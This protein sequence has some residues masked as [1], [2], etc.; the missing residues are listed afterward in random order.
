MIYICLAFLYHSYGKIIKLREIVACIIFTVT[1]VETKPMD[2]IAN[3]IDI[4]CILFRRIGVV[5]T[6]VACAAKLF[7]DS[8]VHAYCLGV[9]YM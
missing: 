4:F 1:P 2:I 3:G 5:K 7:G 9:A 8:E 6:Q